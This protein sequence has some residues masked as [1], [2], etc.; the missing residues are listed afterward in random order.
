MR[1]QDGEAP[2]PPSTATK[3]AFTCKFIFTHCGRDV[4]RYTLRA[5][6]YFRQGRL[7]RVCTISTW[8]IW[9]RSRDVPAAKP[10][11]TVGTVRHHK[12]I[13]CLFKPA[14]RSH[15]WVQILMNNRVADPWHFGVDP[16]PDP[17]TMP[18]TNGSGS[19]FGSG[20]GSGSCYIRHLPSR[21]QQKN[22]FWTHFFCL[23]FFE[24]TFTSFFKDKK[25]KRVTKY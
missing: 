21:C 23:L 10:A 16:D 7:E 15:C 4:Y 17:R 13:N 2:G 6:L 1:S 8:N 18:L 3:Q 22:N 5:V 12:I 24:A 20:F 19:G 25:S 11:W 14:Y 9:Y